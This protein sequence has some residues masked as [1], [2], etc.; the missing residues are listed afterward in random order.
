MED[1]PLVEDENCSWFH[2]IANVR[3][4]QCSE[5]VTHF[6][7]SARDH[8][9]T[10]TFAILYP[11]KDFWPTPSTARMDVVL[12]PAPQGGLSRTRRCPDECL[13][14]AARHAWKSLTPATAPYSLNQHAA[15][16]P[17]YVCHRHACNNCSFIWSSLRSHSLSH[18]PTEDDATAKELVQS[19]SN[20][21]PA[22][23]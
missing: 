21:G 5:G 4:H 2:N 1:S 22:H 11:S 17:V 7:S 3:R 16:S 10:H 8:V 14:H 9:V 19:R 12:S 13:G 18:R 15:R 20:R 23:Q 6:P